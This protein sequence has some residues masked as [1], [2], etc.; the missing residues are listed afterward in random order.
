MPNGYEEDRDRIYRKS[1]ASGSVWQVGDTLYYIG[2]IGSLVLPPTLL[3][4]GIRHFN[5]WR[6][7]LARVGV[8]AALLVTC[9]PAGVLLRAILQ[10]LAEQATGLG[11]PRNH[12]GHDDTSG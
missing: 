3:F 11:P 6:G 10:E 4:V 12:D 8:A 7:F 1:R 9:F 2:L 5:T